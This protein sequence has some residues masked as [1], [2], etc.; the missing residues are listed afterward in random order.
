MVDLVDRQRAMLVAL[1]VVVL[2]LTLVMANVVHLHPVLVHALVVPHD[3]VHLRH[4]GAVFLVDAQP[5]E[6]VHLVTA[7]VIHEEA[8]VDVS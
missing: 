7:V 6:E 2:V 5:E 1:L 8:V 4:H 3:Q